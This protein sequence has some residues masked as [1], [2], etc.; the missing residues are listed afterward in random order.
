MIFLAITVIYIGNLITRVK[1]D[2]PI[3]DNATNIYIKDACYKT[4][5]TLE[6]NTKLANNKSNDTK[7]LEKV[8]EFEITNS[9]ISMA[10]RHGGQVRIIVE[11]EKSSSSNENSNFLKT[12]PKLFQSETSYNKKTNDPSQISLNNS[13]NSFSATELSYVAV[14]RRSSDQTTLWTTNSMALK[15]DLITNDKYLSSNTVSHTSMSTL[16]AE[17]SSNV[18][19][20]LK[21]GEK[22]FEN[23]SIWTNASKVKTENSNL[24]LKQSPSI[25]TNQTNNSVLTSDNITVNLAVGERPFEND[26]VWTTKNTKSELTL[27]TF[28]SE[29]D[30]IH[31]GNLTIHLEEGEK[32]FENCSVWTLDSKKLEPNINTVSYNSAVD[33]SENASFYLAKVRDK[34][35]NNNYKIDLDNGLEFSGIPKINFNDVMIE[36]NDLNDEQDLS[37]IENTNISQSLKKSRTDF[38]LNGIKSNLSLTSSALLTYSKSVDTNYSLQNIN[39]NKSLRFEYHGPVINSVKSKRSSLGS[40]SNQT[41]TESDTSSASISSKS[42]SLVKDKIELYEKR[43]LIRPKQTIPI[44]NMAHNEKEDNYFEEMKLKL[45]KISSS[46]EY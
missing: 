5:P 35:E 42:S 8:K 44:R 7:S 33:S 2:F 40:S 31:S 20:I 14:D 41:S 1:G 25:Q 43:N 22:A 29:L 12:V 6:T 10:N 4:K 16:P 30:R 21:E 27:K 34:I 18:T 26:S 36:Q 23:D 24:T 32:P 3:S 46:A 37:K 19:V 9:E 17:K 38:D 28:N 45:D 11:N 13:N 39:S 15:K